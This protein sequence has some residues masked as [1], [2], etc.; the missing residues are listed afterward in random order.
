MKVPRPGFF[1]VSL[2]AAGL[3][4]AAA[5][6]LEERVELLF[7]PMLGDFVALAP[8]GKRVAFTSPVGS[9]LSIV[10]LGVEPLGTKR[11]LMV[12]DERAAGGPVDTAPPRLRFLRW[13]TA[14]R[15]VYAPEVRTVP[16]PPLTDKNGR[17]TPNP[18]GPTIVSPIFATDA[19]GKQRGTLV[20]A[21]DFQE[22]PD[23]ARQ[24]LGD[25]LRSPLELA[26]QRREPVR[27][28]MPRLDILGFLPRDRE[29]LIFGTRGAYSAPRQHVVDIRTG[30]VREYG[31]DWPAPP[32]EPQVFDWQ[33]LK[34]VGEHRAAAHP[35]VL[36]HDAEM[37]RVQRELDAKFPRRVVELLDW[38]DN[39]ARAICRVTGGS[40]PG[41]LFLYQRTEDLVVELFRRAP[42]LSSTTLH[43]TR[44]FE[45]AATD[46]ARLSGYLTWPLRPRGATPPLVVM[47]PDGFPGGAQPA[48]DPESQVLADLGFAVAR[49]NHRCVGGVR[50]EDRELLRAGLDRTVADDARA[51][52]AWL[53]GRDAARRFDRDQVVAMGHGIGGYLALRALESEPA[54][55][56]GGI[57]LDAPADLPAPPAADREPWGTTS[58][59]AG[60]AAPTPPVLLLVEPAHDATA[61]AVALELRARLQALGCA[62][63][64]AALEPG[65]A[66]ARPA[67]RVAAYRRIGAYLNAQLPAPGV[68][69][70]PTNGGP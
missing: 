28:R 16:L 69:A 67:A 63:E 17:A 62:V 68:A 39:R 48:F 47:F 37:A 61:Q 38:T 31:D 43:E 27:W 55:F 22:T 6:S 40:D 60:A 2:C 53:A 51:T 10:I 57:A 65:F 25:L 23:D 41:R 20:D 7:R 54:A 1:A 9:D 5:P 4:R 33:R 44:F 15:L 29:Q 35:T 13:A 70:G 46:G 30:Q 36:W 3:L 58:V 42:W 21:R 24:S 12:E 45:R 50:P 32:G 8:D 19:D 26:A 49:L 64:H 34:T 52:I 18:D 66:A 14:G 11:T 59:V 56:R